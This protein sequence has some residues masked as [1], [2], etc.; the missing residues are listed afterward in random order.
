MSTTNPNVTNL[1]GTFTHLVDDVQK[2]FRE[3]AC[4][5]KV[6]LN[7][8]WNK[9][10]ENTANI[11]NPTCIGGKFE[12]AIC[13]TNGSEWLSSEIDWINQERLEAAKEVRV[14]DYTKTAVAVSPTAQ[15]TSIINCIYATE[16]DIDP[17]PKLMNPGRF[18]IDTN[19]SAE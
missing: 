7:N 9:I 1:I 2:L 16:A 17:Y 8:L 19:K 6:E 4:P 18:V 10:H 12:L 13:I 11:L 14:S 3:L 15:D 5:T